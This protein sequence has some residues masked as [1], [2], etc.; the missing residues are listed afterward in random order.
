MARDAALVTTWGGAVAG[1]E[2]KSLE[3]FM[4]ALTYWAK[5][6][7]DGRCSEPD[8][9]LAADGSGGML[10]VKGKTDALM[11]ITETDEYTKLVSKAQLI[12][13]ELKVHWYSCGDEEIQ[14]EISLYSQAGN[15]LGYM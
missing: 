12:V 10:I 7:A 4:D 9:L 8:T 3:V 13:G 2:A 1:R 5:Q 6:A 11:E 15:E 14:R